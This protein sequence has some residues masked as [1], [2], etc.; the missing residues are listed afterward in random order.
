MTGAAA[1]AVLAREC[2]VFTRYLVG[3]EPTPYVIGK[4]RAAHHAHSAF[5]PGSRF[6]ARLV[7]VA[8]LHP[9][10]AWLVDAAARFLAPRGLLR[11]KLVLLLAV[12]ETCPPFFADLEH[13]AEGTALRQLAGVAVRMIAFVPVLF[14]G[15]I[16][17]G[18]LR[19]VTPPGAAALR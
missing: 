6:D 9:A 5:V 4:Y 1:D 3:R 16:V 10:G 13:V 7:A 18:L 19:L 12:L 11:K 17:V 15:V 2:Q 8:R 14:V